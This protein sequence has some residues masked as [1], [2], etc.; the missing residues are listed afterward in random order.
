MN[1]MEE[2]PLK[3]RLSVDRLNLAEELENQAQQMYDWSVK[4]A[5]AQLAFDSAKSN[6]AVLTAEL[7]KEI[8]DSPEEY[9]ISKLTETIVTQTILVQPEHKAATS[10]LNEAKHK[11]GIMQAAVSGLTD[12]KRTLTLQVDLFVKDYYADSASKGRN[13][14]LTDSEKEAVRN[15]GARRLEAEREKKEEDSEDS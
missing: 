12:R 9:G 6:L 7:D 4:V 14:P 2:K 13:I 5:D 1:G 3:L 11:L 10:K 15:R 8:R